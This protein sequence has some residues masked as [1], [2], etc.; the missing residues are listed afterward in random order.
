MYA[1]SAKFFL[2]KKLFFIKHS[3]STDRDTVVK[4]SG[5]DNTGRH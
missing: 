5:S 4:L 2:F 1:S 3:H